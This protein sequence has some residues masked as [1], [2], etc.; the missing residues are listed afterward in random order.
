MIIE[1]DDDYVDIVVQNCLVQDYVS[2]SNDLKQ[3]DNMHKDDVIACTKT[4]KALAVL[5]QWYFAHGEFKKAVNK[6]RKAK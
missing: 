5:G 6:A 4:V 1:I 3:H 2:L